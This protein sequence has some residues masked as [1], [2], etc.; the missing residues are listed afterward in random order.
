MGRPELPPEQRSKPRTIWMPDSEWS[1]VK[2]HPKGWVRELI[3][4]AKPSIKA[5][6]EAAGIDTRHI[7]GPMIRDTITAE[8]NKCSN[9]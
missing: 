5:T 2:A 3:R 6:L 1:K 7:N 9:P 4:N 8:G